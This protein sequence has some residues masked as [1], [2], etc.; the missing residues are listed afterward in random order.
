M[1]APG[2]LVTPSFLPCSSQREDLGSAHSLINYWCI[3]FSSCTPP[4]S[5]TSL[6]E[7]D[8]PRRCTTSSL[9]PCMH[10]AEAQGHFVYLSAVD[11]GE[12][13]VSMWPPEQDSGVQCSNKASYQTLRPPNPLEAPSTRLM[14]KGPA[15]CHGLRVTQGA[16][17]AHLPALQGP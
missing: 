11:P 14:N 6:S 16:P 9:L 2:R 1:P 13:H 3:M 15:G 7:G 4:W 17:L 8:G 5:P 12:P 10:L